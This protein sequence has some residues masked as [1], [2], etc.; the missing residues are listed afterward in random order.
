MPAKQSSPRDGGWGVT[1]AD[2]GQAIE[3]HELHHNCTVEFSTY[4]YKKYKT[5]THRVYTVVCHTRWRRDTPH[6]VRGW[7]ACDIGHGSGAAT[8]P[9]G[10][11]RAMLQSVDNL[12]EKRANPRKQF[13]AARLPG[14][15]E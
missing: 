11:L 13:V 7:G 4:Y 12:E 14:I 6:E 10:M 8:M 2:L 15:D 1:Y 3:E 9:S 5:A